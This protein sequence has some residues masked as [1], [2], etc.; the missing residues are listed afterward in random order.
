VFNVLNVSLA[1]AVIDLGVVGVVAAGNF[2]TGENISSNT[3]TCPR[4]LG[5]STLEK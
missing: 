4:Q 2:N 5:K 1:Q 3:G